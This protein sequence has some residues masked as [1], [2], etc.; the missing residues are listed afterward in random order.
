[1]V[2]LERTADSAA[3]MMLGSEEAQSEYDFVEPPSC[4]FL[5]PVNFSVLLEPYQTNC[6]GNHLSEDAY[7]RLQ[8][9][10]RPCPMCSEKK[11]EATKDKYHRR[12]VKSL[13]V[14]CPHKA[15]GC[16]WEGELGSLEQHLNTNSSAGEC[17]YVDVVCPYACGKRVQR[18]NFEE[19]QCPMRPFT[20]QYCGFE[21]T[22]QEVTEKHFPVCEKYPVLCPNECGEK[23]MERQNLKQ[24]LEQTCPLE[25]IDCEFSYAGC[26][27]KLQRCLISAHMK[28]G[29]EAHLSLLA[30]E[31]P[32]LQSQIKQQ[33]DQIQQQGNQITMLLKLLSKKNCQ[34]PLEFTMSKFEEH[35]RNN[36]AWDSPPFYSHIGGYK[37]YLRVYANGVNN[38]KNSVVLFAVLV[39]GE[40]DDHLEWPM[41]AQLSVRVGKS[42][43]PKSV[44]NMHCKNEVSKPSEDTPLAFG[45]FPHQLCEIVVMN[46]S[47]VLCIV[48]VTLM[49][50]NEA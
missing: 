17:R 37:M 1:M 10:R 35:K 18:C 44:V 22:Y 34:P 9:D 45:Y 28:E 12:R 6:C 14:R 27:V 36:N 7:L 20:C 21:A 41:R 11:F 13:A 50:K 30:Q 47:L 32:S 38:V 29:M 25:V 2:E 26:G 43:D 8:K 4:D 15:E 40:F 49:K 24:H 23:E 19:H 33:A 3:N 16:E 42:L 39:G 31:V 48:E 5:C 46:D